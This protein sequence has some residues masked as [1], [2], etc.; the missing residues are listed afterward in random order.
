MHVCVLARKIFIVFSADRWIQRTRAR[1]PRVFPTTVGRLRGFDVSA[2]SQSLEPAAL[3]SSDGC[4]ANRAAGEGR[5]VLGATFLHG[6]R[7]QDC[8]NNAFGV[9]G[10]RG[11]A[12]SYSPG[13]CVPYNAPTDPKR[14]CIPRLLGRRECVRVCVCVCCAVLPRHASVDGARDAGR[15]QPIAR[16]AALPRRLRRLFLRHDCVGDAHGRAALGRQVPRA[17]PVFLPKSPSLNRFPPSRTCGTGLLVVLRVASS[18]FTPRVGSRPW[19]LLACL[20]PCE[21]RV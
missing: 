1:A 5:A 11:R 19:A 8:R 12:A 4:S 10:G 20:V 9:S 15:R 6:T 17:P 16:R 14:P 2:S 18:S 13:A 21:G 3:R 7:G